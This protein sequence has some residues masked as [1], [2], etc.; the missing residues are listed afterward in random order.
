MCLSEAQT[1]TQGDGDNLMARRRL[2]ELPRPSRILVVTM[3]A[4]AALVAALYLTTRAITVAT[5][6]DI[7]RREVSSAAYRARDALDAEVGSLART[8]ADYAEW[9]DALAFARGRLP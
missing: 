5:Y 9:D 2:A 7:E 1:G 3:L 6:E 8:A 4:I